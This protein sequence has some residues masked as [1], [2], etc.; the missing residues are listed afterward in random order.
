MDEL[1][2]AVK[3]V[4]LGCN[5]TVLTLFPGK[6]LFRAVRVTE[7]PIHQ[8]RISYPPSRLLDKM[9]RANDVGH[10]MFYASMADR[11]GL[12]PRSN[13]LACVWESKVE[14]GE[15]LAVGEWEVTE[16]LR[17]YPFGFQ[18]PEMGNMERGQQPWIH[19]S[20][21]NE[22]IT[23]IKAWESEVFTRTVNTG[24]ENQYKL[25]VALT[26]YAINLRAPMGGTDRV[27]G[28]VYPSVATHL[29]SD[30]VCLTPEAADEGLAL[31]GVR[32]M[33]AKNLRFFRENDDR[34]DDDAVGGA[35]VMFHDSS[36]PCDGSGEVRWPKRWIMRS[37]FTRP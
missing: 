9:G 13:F 4:H 32:I 5:V 16:E 19:S 27:S 1:V 33:D 3:A 10:A 18:A 7:R 11:P 29:C 8:S 23:L 30:N 35:E 31:L 17:V 14:D 25:S 22:S 6:R 28:I 26:K 34:P 12:E 21:P 24:E 36:Y 37:I 20:M 15:L 2:A